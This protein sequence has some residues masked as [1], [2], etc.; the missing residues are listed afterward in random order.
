MAE[1]SGFM[2]IQPP[3]IQPPYARRKLVRGPDGT[4]QVV[5]VDQQGNTIENLAGYNI[6]ESGN[7]Y[8]P[9]SLGRNDTPGATNEKSNQQSTARSVI[10]E[11]TRGERSDA[12]PGSGNFGRSQANNFGYIDKPGF[13]GFTGMLP[14]PLG[15]A[16]KGA[17]AA[18]NAN[19]VAAVNAA[20]GMLGLPGTGLGGSIKGTLK[21]NKGQVADVTLGSST[22]ATPVG[23]EALSPSGMTNMT[24]QEAALRAQAVGGIQLATDEQV[25]ARNAA[26]DAE[27]GKP[28]FLGRISTVANNFIDDLFGVTPSY[29]QP[30]E[31]AAAKTRSQNTGANFNP[32]R[33]GFADMIGY[34]PASGKN[35]TST[36]ISPVSGAARSTAGKTGGGR[37]DSSSSGM[38]NRASSGP[39]GGRLAGP[40]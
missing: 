13:M 26:F 8:N 24:P 23:L 35:A 39:T 28:G 40:V 21:D 1:Q 15:L 37:S 27:F 5:Y 38:G 3:A 22:Y 29:Y 11:T 16:G 19:N 36:S 30:D 32:S 20:R 14:G 9:D 12:Q 25:A 34:T 4:V 18:I 17:N 10:Q 31:A 33:S 7:Y 6:A 2:A